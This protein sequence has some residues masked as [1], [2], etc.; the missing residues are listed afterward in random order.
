MLPNTCSS[1]RGS[2]R[3]GPGPPP[4]RVRS[5]GHT[6]LLWLCGAPGRTPC[7]TYG[8]ALTSAHLQRRFQIREQSR[9]HPQR[10]D[11]HPPLGVVL[12]PGTGFGRPPAARLSLGRSGSF[13]GAS[14]RL[15]TRLRGRRW[16]GLLAAA[17]GPGLQVTR[18]SPLGQRNKE[19]AIPKGT[20][21]CPRGPYRGVRE[22]LSTTG[23]LAGLL[24]RKAAP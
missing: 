2:G 13:T 11:H 8:R 18:R 14:S 22:A 6:L 7:A 4:S 12:R 15:C 10:W 19:P 17:R 23:G 9:A 24:P 3:P 16:C 5:H 21:S 1:C 20:S